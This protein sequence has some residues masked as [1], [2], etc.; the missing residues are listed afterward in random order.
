MRRRHTL[1]W[2]LALLGLVFLWLPIL[3]IVVVSFDTSNYLAFPPAGFT[4]QNYLEVF[5][6]Q[7]FV[8]AFVLSTWMGLVVAMVSTGLGVTAALGARRLPARLSGA[9]SAFVLSPLLMP[10]VVLGLAMMLVYARIELLGTATGIMLAHVVITLPYTFRV[11]L[12]SLETYDASSEDAARV[13]GAPPL[14]VFRRITLPLITPGVASALVLSFLVAFDESVIV[15]FI[16]S[17]STTTLPVALLQHVEVSADPVVAALSVILVLISAA[18]MVVV[19]SLFG[20]RRAV[21]A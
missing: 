6:D 15:L 12:A 5:Q 3:V 13:L 11:V 4:L 10:S 17:R 14:T 9:V 16:S 1:L 8:D 2:P 20:L 7:E 19:N 18:V 21:A